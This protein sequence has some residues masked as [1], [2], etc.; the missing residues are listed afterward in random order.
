LG[1]I[2]FIMM[3]GRPPFKCDR[4]SE[5]YSQIKAVRYQCPPTFTP[6]LV[7]LLGKILVRDPSKR[8]TI[9]D[10]RNDAWYH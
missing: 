1:I 7:A 10:I 5:L 8:A 9:D 3:S 4:I 2:L 6:S